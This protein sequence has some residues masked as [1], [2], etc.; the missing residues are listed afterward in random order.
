M[1]TSLI[2]KVIPTLVLATLSITAAH[3]ECC[4]TKPIKRLAL[5]EGGDKAGGGGEP[6]EIDIDMIRGDLVA[7]INAGG[8]RDLRLP[9]RVSYAEY[10]QA[11]RQILTPHTVVL[12][13]VDKD[14]N[15]DPELSVKVAGQEK[16]CRGFISRNDARPHILCHRGR[17]KTASEGERYQLIHHEYAGLAQ[18]ELNIG[19]S[20]D[21]SIS[22]QISDYLIPVTVLRL[23]VRGVVKPKEVPTS[24][25][26]H[27]STVN[28]YNTDFD[29][30]RSS[31]ELV[32]LLETKGYKLTKQRK[33]AAITISAEF[34]RY[35][36]RS[37]TDTYLNLSIW[38][39]KGFH[40]DHLIRGHGVIP[41]PRKA[42]IESKMESAKSVAEYQALQT[43][44]RTGVFNDTPD[45]LLDGANIPTCEE[46]YGKKAL[47]LTN[48]QQSEQN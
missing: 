18:V 26:L 2:R 31:D 37:S 17:Y 27:V 11:M 4:D 38:H 21:Y 48:D 47:T 39:R 8:A 5:T 6:M 44:L 22:K 43:E 28:Y 32:K 13:F 1:K 10:T 45:N 3:A 20:S 30:R 34:T 16:T 36:P 25:L 33:K 40:I 46:F 7:W 14:S 19:A 35:S 12:T 24:C 23:A 15:A 9:G 41:D 29:D 42:E